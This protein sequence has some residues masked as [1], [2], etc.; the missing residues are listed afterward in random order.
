MAAQSAA[1]CVGSPGETAAD[2]G[3]NPFS[4]LDTPPDVR[5]QR[6]VLAEPA[7]DLN[8]NMGAPVRQDAFDHGGETR[9]RGLVLVHTT[10]NTDWSNLPLSGLFVDILRR[11]VGL[12]AGVV[13][14]DQT[15]LLHRHRHSMDTA[16][17]VRRQRTQSAFLRAIFRKPVRDLLPPGYYGLNTGRRAFCVV[18]RQRLKPIGDLPSGIERA[19]FVPAPSVDFKPWLLLSSLLLAIGDL[20]VSFVLRGLI[21]ARRLTVTTA[22][23]AFAVSTAITIPGPAVAQSPVGRTQQRARCESVG[24]HVQNK[25]CLRRNRRPQAR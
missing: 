15:A 24:S 14:E 22:I 5:V 4:G 12:S 1:G 8:E 17:W 3:I 10:A 9:A 25:A 2:G 20:L 6:Q 13:G 21:D 7:R 11:I 18:R 23:A 19:G 16:D